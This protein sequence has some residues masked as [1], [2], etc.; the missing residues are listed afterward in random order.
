MSETRNGKPSLTGFPFCRPIIVSGVVPLGFS[1]PSQRSALAGHY[2][3]ADLQPP[4]H[5]PLNGAATCNPLE[6]EGADERAAF[7]YVGPHDA[8]ALSLIRV[9]ERESRHGVSQLN[10]WRIVDKLIAADMIAGAQAPRFDTREVARDEP[11]RGVVIAG[12]NF[13]L[14]G[15]VFHKD[16]VVQQATGGGLCQFFE[17]FSLLA[18]GPLVDD[19]N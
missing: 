3:C 16:D 1:L 4:G 15:S 11:G 17:S 10:E 14:D 7:V 5:V 9:A 12:G 6:R 2:L 18:G 13:E 19:Q 8:E